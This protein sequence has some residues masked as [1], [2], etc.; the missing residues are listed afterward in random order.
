MFKLWLRAK[1][2]M[3]FSVSVKHKKKQKIFL[4][5][6]LTLFL[7]FHQGNNTCIHILP[8]VSPGIEITDFQ[9]PDK[10]SDT[11]KYLLDILKIHRASCLGL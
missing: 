6:D 1:Q 9:R 4:H 3:K 10:T 5:V 11:I 2:A 7:Q 8:V